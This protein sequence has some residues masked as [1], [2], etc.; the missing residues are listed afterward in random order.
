V[1]NPESIPKPAVA[2]GIDAEDLLA[3][4]VDLWIDMTGLSMTMEGEA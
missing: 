2:S 4:R 3:M 1:I